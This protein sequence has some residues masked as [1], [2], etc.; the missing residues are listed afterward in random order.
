MY[1]AAL[2]ARRGLLIYSIVLVARLSVPGIALG[3][4]T[5]T[6]FRHPLDTDGWRLT[7]DFCVWNGDWGGYHLGEDLVVSDGS[8]LPVY[9]PANG[10]TKHNASRT[11]YG[12][13]VVIEH[14]LPDGS[15]VTSVLG[16]LRSAGLIPTETDVTKGQLIGYLS[17]TASENG[18]Y[19]FTHLHFGIRNGGYSATWVYFG[20]GASC[21]GWQDPSAFIAS[22]GS[23]TSVVMSTNLFIASTRANPSRIYSLPNEYGGQAPFESEKNFKGSFKLRNAGASTAFLSDYGISIRTSSDNEL[24]RLTQG[25]ATSLAPG[26][27]SPLFDKR[28]YILDDRLPGGSATRLRAQVV[29]KLGSTWEL[30][31][32][33]GTFAE[34]DVHPRPPLADGML[35]KR[36]RAASSTD[37]EDARIYYHSRGSYPTGRKWRGTEIGLGGLFPSWST[38]YYVY[39][40]A[41][42]DGLEN[43]A[44]PN[45]NAIIPEIVG[46]NLLYKAQ[47]NPT[48]YIIEPDA[49]NPVP[50]LRS[51]PFHDEAAFLAYGYSIAVLQN[52]SLPVT[53]AQIAWLQDP[54]RYPVG[55]E[56]RAASPTPTYRSTSTPIPTSTVT[57]SYTA[58]PTHTRTVT[59]TQTKT[60][61]PTG[62]K[63][64]TATHSASATPPPSRTS[65]REPSATAPRPSS[66]PTASATVVASATYTAVST[67]TTAARATAT[68]T[69]SP[70]GTPSRT[71]TPTATPT[72][73][74][75][76][77]EVRIGMVAG[78]AG[79][80]VVLPVWLHAGGQ[81][82]VALSNDIGF[83]PRVAPIARTNGRPHCIVNRDIDKNGTTFAFHPNGC[84]PG[85]SCTAI[86][87]IV[88]SLDDLA[89][90]PDGSLLY[91]CQIDLPAEPGASFTLESLEVIATDERGEVVPSTGSSG[92]LR[93]SERVAAAIDIGSTVASPSRP[94]AVDVH[95]RVLDSSD[96]IPVAAENVIR[97]PVEAAIAALSATR[98]DCTI[99]PAINKPDSAFAFLPN[100]CT[101]SITCT[102][103][104]ALILALDNTEPIPDG[105]R[106]YSCTV[107]ALPGAAPGIYP[108]RID[109]PGTSNAA[110][111]PLATT[112]N[113]GTVEITR[114]CAGDCN[115]D[116]RITIDELVRAVN[117]A[118]GTNPVSDCTSLDING[119]GRVSIDEL[120]RAV[121][122]ALA[123]CEWSSE[124]E[125]VM[126][127]NRG[128]SRTGASFG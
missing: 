27:E 37:P 47:S 66:S 89:P 102:G 49:A 100:G 42:V 62:T 10:R 107:Q 52:E 91:T 6:S 18:G 40:R 105:A 48:I 120:V 96:G 93:I 67:P 82:V 75:G 1:P 31:T 124:R 126:R 57:R 81:N 32:G 13:V 117:I 53:G 74:P 60:V 80:R 38:E 101:P 2:P 92:M 34:F 108:L 59:S 41:T 39:P 125:A 103:I 43:P 76:T 61:V 72:R 116:D 29:I 77:A 16:H 19:S 79:Q 71:H 69:P 9:S 58:A 94:G 17:E 83:D 26:Q 11:G 111:L 73:R 87:A 64:A 85:V 110:G 25:T 90:I 15:L 84:T 98:P 3:Y 123:G 104:R 88:L 114:A 23:S 127:K 46:R 44:I 106:L 54:G 78:V 68:K 12:R 5:A 112:G 65:T 7:Q 119:D 24:F 97:F 70:V 28:G 109:Q 20:Y 95:L 30:L 113:D 21:S 35:I 55:S 45:T 4:E 14:R 122:G 56:I 33:S 118:L 63:S 99:N 121:N 128:L 22:R 36:P 51:R 8:E 50:S 86:R 115:G